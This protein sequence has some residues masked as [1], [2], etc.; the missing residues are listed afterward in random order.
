VSG[1]VRINHN[2]D[3]LLKIGGKTYKAQYDAASGALILEEVG[4]DGKPVPQPKPGAGS[5]DKTGEAKHSDEPDIPKDMESLKLAIERV[6]RQN[7]ATK[8]Q[9]NQLKGKLTLKSRALTKSQ[10]GSKSIH[11]KKTKANAFGYNVIL[12]V[13]N[14]GSMSGPKI[15]LANAVA[16]GLHATLRNTEGVN[17]KVL[18]FTDEMRQKAGWEDKKVQEMNAGGGNSDAAAC[19]IAMTRHFKD[20]PNENYRNI[21]LVLSDGEPCA[22]TLGENLPPLDI[23]YKE[24]G[25]EECAQI[26]QFL[27]RTARQQDVFIAGLGILHDSTQIPNSRMIKNLKDVQKSLVGVLKG[28]IET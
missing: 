17:V 7:R 22:G 13:D 20:A 12:L 5:P 21:L 23:W 27:S 10:T 14:S 16:K 11:S 2:V 24:N 28:A 3:G 25:R 26:A 1:A 9:H 4:A 19:Y 15:D 6:L 18:A 8:L